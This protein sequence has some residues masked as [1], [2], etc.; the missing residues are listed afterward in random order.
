MASGAG[1][2]LGRLQTQPLRLLG[3]ERVRT[4]AGEFDCD[5]FVF[6]DGD[7]QL[8]IFGPDRLLARMIWKFA[9]V[10]YVLTEYRSD[11]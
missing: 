5:H 4:P 1:G 11:D 9:D 7:P 2:P 8:F 6:G 3:T 10:E